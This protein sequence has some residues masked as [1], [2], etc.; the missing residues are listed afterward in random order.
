MKMVFIEKPASCVARSSAPLALILAT[1]AISQKAEGINYEVYPGSAFYLT[2]MLDRTQWAYVADQSNGLYHHPVGFSDL[3]VPQETTYTSHFSNR[4]AM[5]EG[6]MGSG[7]TTG[8]VTNL[9]LMTGYGLTPV[10]AFVNRPASNI[11]VWRQ[12][13]RNNAAQGA[14]TYEMLAPHRLDDTAAGWNDPLWDYARSNMGVAG[15]IGS[16]VDAPVYLFV[17]QG[18][19]YRQSIYDMRDWT[20]DNGKKFN[21]LISPNNSYNAA[22]LADT[23][24]TVRAMEDSGHEPD[25]YG[26]VLY[27]ERPVDLTP[28][29]VTVNGV[30]QAATTI[31]GLA[32]WLLKHRDGE[33]GTL[34][35]SAIRSGTTQA[36]GV[37]N[38]TLS[39]AAQIIPV[40]S[41]ASQTYTLRTNNSS[42]WLDYA[43]VLR[44]RT[45]GSLH[46]WTITFAKGGQDITAAMLSGS[47]KPFLGADRWMPGTQHELSVTI[48]PNGTPG[49]LKLI[50][51]AL[52]HAGVDQALDVISFESANV[53]NTPPTLALNTIPQIT[54]EAL[55]CGPLWFT[56]GDAETLSTSLTI[57]ATSSNTQLIPNA[58]LTLGKSG[59]QR[60][61]RV[62]PASGK[63]GSATISVTASDG[64]ASVTRT[65]TLTVERTT[66]LPVVK[67]NNPLNLELTNSW[68][69]A[70]TPGVTDQ[71][72][73]DSTITSVNSVNVGTNLEV[74]GLRLT[75]PGGDVTIGGSA[76]LTLGTAGVDLATST[77]SLFL[78]AAIN[79]DEATAWNIATNRLVR[80]TR[81]VGGFGA[82]AKSGN[83]RLELLGDDSFVGPLA[84]SAGELVNTCAGG[85]SS[86]TISTNG[87]LRISHS[88]AF[89]AGGLSITAANTSTGRLEL[90]GGI[91]VLTGK[92]VSINARSSNT[93]ALSAISGN[94]TFGG[95]ISFATGGSIYGFNSAG[96]LLTLSGNLSSAAT[97]NRN[98]TLRGTGD[99]IITGAISDGAGVVGIIKSGSGTWTMAGTHSFTGTISHQ[100]GTLNIQTPLP[101]QA[102]TVSAGATLAGSGTL[103][104]AVSIAGIHSPGDGVGSQSLEGT[105]IYQG[106]S[107]IRMELAGQSPTADSIQAASVTVAAGARI[108]PV[109]TTADFSQP[110]WREAREWPVLA[111]A[112][113]SGSFLLGASPVDA[114]GKPSQPFGQFSLAQATSGVNLVWAPAPPFQVWQ[115]ENFGNS[116]NDPL[117]AGP[118]RDPDGDGWSNENEWISGTLPDQ[119]AS[120]L[121]AA[122]TANNISFDRAAGR[123]YRVETSTGLSGGWSTHTL[124]PSGTGRITIPISPGDAPHVFYR[125]AVSLPSLP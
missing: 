74:G 101:L 124:V 117:T 48:T 61:L 119:S 25:V 13:V 9:Q 55:P 80:V 67:A 22:L 20:V 53:G 106:T 81:G 98:F 56:C 123:A 47:G 89:G 3:D 52:P 40:S 66:V 70:V 93:D 14:P 79:V 1:L 34:D 92:A 42:P 30:D 31:T 26:V 102:V 36:A 65:F 75:S 29:K 60:W 16:G 59:I 15:C 76:R 19:T 58:N 116:W 51:E 112:S 10:A 54:R 125:I 104:G 21:Y 88:A 105:L 23:Q 17:N 78:D 110:F 122:I 43:G 82:I 111:S 103:G 33:P 90:T 46:N 50:I 62:T 94:N 85:Q 35:L 45:Q 97:G 118:E 86:T 120:R 27:G 77:R 113:L 71:A 63:W 72:V 44:A 73:W 2:Q 39:N 87:I 7:S 4:F 109:A 69:G 99:G 95:N 57:T 38:P 12:L 68:Q 121:N 64:T 6:D 107:S 24:A 100:E 114:L 83:G 115:F 37:T 32:Y 18:S 28:E 108:D 11:A 41:T 96:G 5:V 49:P 84:V 91:S 8:D